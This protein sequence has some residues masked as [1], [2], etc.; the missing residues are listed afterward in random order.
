MTP[1]EIIALTSQ[2]IARAAAGKAV[3]PL[4]DQLNPITTP[5]CTP[6]NESTLDLLKGNA[7]PKWFDRIFIYLRQFGIPTISITGPS[8]TGKTHIH[9]HLAQ[10]L[11]RRIE[12]TSEMAGHRIFTA[13]SVFNLVDTVGRPGQLNFESHTIKPICDSDVVMLVFAGGFLKAMDGTDEGFL[14]GKLIYKRWGKTGDKSIDVDLNKRGKKL[15]HYVAQCK[16]YELEWLQGLVE[17]LSKR[18]AGPWNRPRK[19]LFLFLNKADL[20]FTDMAEVKAGYLDGIDWVRPQVVDMDLMEAERQKFWIQIQSL[21][22]L[23]NFSDPQTYLMVGSTGTSNFAKHKD[24]ILPPAQMNNDYP[25]L[26]MRLLEAALWN[27]L[28]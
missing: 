27:S 14:D 2:I 22:K 7:D 18:P 20:W 17:T 25:K 28:A 11:A 5:G 19:R 12:A 4:L 26:S 6:L 15:E 13:S 1:L 8:G 3:G 24:K 9:T 21:R 16:S 10:R 23:L